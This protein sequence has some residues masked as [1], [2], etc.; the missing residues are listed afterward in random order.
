MLGMIEMGLQVDASVLKV[1]ACGS[2]GLCP[3]R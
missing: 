2:A 3:S 1:E